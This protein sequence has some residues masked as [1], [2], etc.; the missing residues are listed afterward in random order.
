ML[1]QL[2]QRIALLQTEGGAAL[3]RLLELAERYGMD[4]ETVTEETH[5]PFGNGELT[6]FPPLGVSGSNE[7]GL[8]VLASAGEHDFLITGD[9]ER[10]TEKKLI[11][12]YELPELDVL[13]AGHHG[14]KNSTSKELLDAVTPGTVIISVGSNSYGH[15]AEDTLRRL[16]RAGCDIYR[17][18]RHGTVYLSFD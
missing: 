3:D 17:T 8:T 14:S 12:T 7:L 13:M 1:S 11:E 4:V 16:A 18:D 15:P 5:L 9:M 2:R 10:A 6:I